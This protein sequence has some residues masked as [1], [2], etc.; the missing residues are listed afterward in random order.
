MFFKGSRYENNRLFAADESAEVI[1]NGVR[2]RDIGEATGVIEHC[3]KVG[4]RLDLLARHY[5]NNDRL[6]WRILDANPQIMF[7]TDLLLDEW[8]GQVLLIPKVRQ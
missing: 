1:F 6:W 5:Y 4:D 3:I 8:L 7:A 2:A